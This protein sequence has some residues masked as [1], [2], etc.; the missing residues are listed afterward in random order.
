MF[1]SITMASST[2]RP[3]A[4]TMASRVSVLIEKPDSAI[5]EKQP[6]SDTGMVSSGMIEARNVRRNSRITSATRITASR[7]VV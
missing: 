6:I 4:S 5:S 7:M 1:S 2:T 3:M